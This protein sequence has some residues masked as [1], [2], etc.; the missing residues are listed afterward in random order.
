MS[1][2][3]T[4]LDVGR[5]ARLLTLIAVV[6][7]IS[8]LASASVLPSDVQ[9]IAFVAVGSVAFVTAVI[10]FLIAVGSSYDESMHRWDDRFALE[11]EFDDP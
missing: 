2:E 7:M 10:G 3:S 11:S 5:L 9:A 1:T 6:T 8:T 4:G